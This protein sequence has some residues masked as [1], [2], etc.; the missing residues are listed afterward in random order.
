MLDL[1]RRT[2]ARLSLSLLLLLGCLG[3][4]LLELGDGALVGLDLTTVGF[5][6]QMTN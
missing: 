3:G 1:N 6:L 2:N 4:F 5:N